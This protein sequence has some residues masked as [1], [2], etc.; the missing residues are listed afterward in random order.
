MKLT[1]TL[2]ALCVACLLVACGGADNTDTTPAKPAVSLDD[3]SDRD[4]RFRSQYKAHMRH[5]WIDCNRI[6]GAG[7]G[8]LEPTWHEIRASAMDV[9]ARAKLLGGYWADIEARSGTIVECVEDEDRI[10]ASDELKA[11]GAACDGC[12]LATWSPAYLHVT[13]DT[14]QRWLN[15]QPAEHGA[16]E[17]DVEPPPAIPNRAVM[18]GLWDRY[19]KAESRLTKWDP[20]GVKNHLEAI[21]PVAAERAQLWKTVGDNAEKLVALATA[22]KRDGMKEA[23]TAITA[24]CAGCHGKQTDQR[25]IMAPM[26]WE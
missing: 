4:W 22:G 2:L 10:G 23:Y 12:H 9:A 13:L 24:A 25:E 8:D 11:M 5:L 21:R 20:T 14:M 1:L 3:Q 26:A 16:G 19:Q 17:V 6:A 18:Q 7:R 15:N